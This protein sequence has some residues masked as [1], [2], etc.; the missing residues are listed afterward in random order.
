MPGRPAAAGAVVAVAAGGERADGERREQ[1]G[2]DEGNDRVPGTEQRG[3]QDPADDGG[4][5]P[6]EDRHNDPDVLA[7]GYDQAGYRAD[8]KADEDPP[9]DDG[10]RDDHDF[11]YWLITV[12]FASSCRVT[13]RRRPR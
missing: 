1:H 13:P 4:H 5:D 12:R 7:A 8:H 3:R 6:D 10:K 11:S 2:H 9:D